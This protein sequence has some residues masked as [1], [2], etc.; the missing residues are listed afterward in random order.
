MNRS[1]LILVSL[2]LTSLIQAATI[3]VTPTGTDPAGGNWAAPASLVTALTI[4]KSNDAIWLAQGTYTHTATFTVASNGVALYGGFT[5]GM[6]TLAERDWTAYP[7]ILN[8][9][10]ANRRVVTVSGAAVTLDGLVIT[11]SA[12]GGLTKTAAG[13]LGLANCRIVNNLA[14]GGLSGVGCSFTAGT[15]LM[16]NCLVAGNQIPYNNGGYIGGKYGLGVYS[17]GAT[18]DLVDCVFSNQ[19]CDKVDARGCYGGGLS[20]DNGTLRVLRTEFVNNSGPDNGGGGSGAYL[21]NNATMSAVFSNCV[22]RGNGIYD[23]NQA[24]GA[25]VWANLNAARTAAFVNCT[26]AYNVNSN[27][28]GGALY[29]SAGTVILKNVI[30]WTNTVTKAGSI[31]REI[32]VAG[33]TLRASYG[34]L[35]GTVAPW[36]F[37]GGGSAV[38]SNIMT[39]DPLFASSTDLHLRSPSGRWA[40]G[41]FVT[42]DTVFSPCLDAGDPADGVG[43]EPAENGSRINAGAYGGTAQAS[44]S[45]NTAPEVVNR[46]A[47]ALDFTRLSLRGELANATPVL[48]DVVLCYGTNSV[49]GDT[50]NGWQVVRPL[51]PP[52]QTGTLFSVTTPY[53]LTN[54]VYYV[55]WYAVN[56]FGTSWSAVSNFTTA[57]SYPPLYGVG[58]GGNVIHV[59]ADATGE[60]DGRDWHNAFPKWADAIAMIGGTRTNLWITG[61]TYSEG[62]VLTLSAAATVVGGFAGTETAVSQRALTN[63]AGVATNYTAINGENIHKCLSITAAGSL[64]LDTLSFSNSPMPRTLE[65]SGAGALT[66]NNCRIEKNTMADGYTSGNGN[67]LGAYFSAGSVVMT[68]CV[69]ADNRFPQASGDAKYSNRGIGVYGNNVILD[70]AGCL[71]SNQVG[72][73]STARSLRGAGLAFDNGTCRVVRTEFV[74]NLGTGNGGGGGAVYLGNGAALSVFFSN[75]L[76]RANMVQHNGTAGYGGAVFSEM[77]AARTAAFINCTFAFNTNANSNGK[78]GAVFMSSGNLSLKN[79]ILWT[80]RV[81]GTGS[82]GHEIA[83]SGGSLNA[84]Y[85]DLS[86]L[87]TPFIDGSPTLANCKADNPLFAGATDF[88]LQ[89]PAG[90][91]DPGTK[92]FVTTDTLYSPCIDAGNPADP[93]GSEPLDNSNIRINM[94]TYGGTA[95]ASKS[96]PAIPP[97]LADR[98]ATVY[99]HRATVSGELTNSAYCAAGLFL[100]YGTNSIASDTTNGWGAVASLGERQNGVVFSTVTPGLLP[101]TTYYYRWCAVNNDGTVWT[102][103]GSFQTGLVPPGGG[104]DIIHVDRNATGAAD[105]TDWANAFTKLAD[106]ITASS[107]ARTNL[108]MTGGTY[109]HLVVLTVATNAAFYGGFQ[110][111]EIAV[112]QRAATNATGVI[113]N[114]TVVDGQGVVPCLTI[115]GGNVWLEAMTFTNAPN[116]SALAKSGTGILTVNNC[117]VLGNRC[118]SINVTG[119]GCTFTGGTVLMTNCEVANN[120]SSNYGIM[121][122]GLYA[123]GATLDLVDCVVSNNNGA[124][125]ATRQSYG[126]GLYFDNGTL[127]VLRTDFLN[128]T[129]GVNNVIGGGGAVYLGAN[130]NMSARFRNCVFQGN[131]ALTTGAGKGG[132]IWANLNSIGKT[133]TV[134]NCTF[135]D[136]RNET[137]GAGGALCVSKGTL[138]MKNSIFWTN[139]VLDGVSG[140][141]V[142]ADS[143]NS[144]VILNYSCLTGTNAPH[145]VAAN[146]AV[147]ELGAGL[148][149]NDPLYAGAT[150][151]HLKS[152]GGRWNPAMADWVSDEVTS[153]CLDAGDPADPVGLEP[154]PN[155]RLINTGAYGGTAQASKTWRAP[156]TLIMVR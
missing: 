36:L 74:S 100:C 79:C 134:E 43:A 41:S 59:K 47:V 18:L 92:S 91:W 32:Y 17:L 33:G 30:L 76:F 20:F 111:G 113:T 148:M 31:G 5:N 101:Q 69:I 80:N 106:A 4:G 120:E 129:G 73:A 34:C 77:N 68:N 45:L 24:Y 109:G 9:Q 40:G 146:G 71:F 112:S 125:Y 153:P 90:R 144:R 117:R 105:G 137:T 65:K 126:V 23:Y 21:G 10:A 99:W 25:A 82:I 61:G 56:A 26:F 19:F 116:G 72:D 107:G 52:Q 44:K 12:G 66:L 89:S 124:G 64:W 139:A 22:F 16:T 35:S 15:V 108:W 130:T 87:V 123:S 96:P 85:C 38:L 97:Q 2:G 122:F 152:K 110:G 62:V 49:A 63:A 28:H 104:A 154:K 6:A 114:Y 115:T 147:V 143:A 70:I 155:G 54:T 128:N 93:I 95:Q 140:R 46:G 83:L 29:Q 141:E 86:G 51:Y 81:T 37:V 142:Y 151:V 50:T 102:S 78:G 60:G 67:G 55:R 98:G 103:A 13:S 118:A 58:G 39:N 57:A 1:C 131:R 149:T 88:H 53:L 42:T 75:C 132:A 150:D 121:G 14:V 138:I 84:S 94:G 7:V 156:G 3:Y 133:V 127:N 8:G 135:A 145:V 119:I 27:G 11:N 136:N 48:A